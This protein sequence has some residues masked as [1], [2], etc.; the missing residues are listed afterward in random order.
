MCYITANNLVSEQISKQYTTTTGEVLFTPR[1]SPGSRM[2]MHRPS[3]FNMNGK[4]RP[5]PL[6]FSSGVSVSRPSAAAYS[7]ALRATPSDRDFETTD[8]VEFL[9]STPVGHKF[10]RQAAD[11]GDDSETNSDGLLIHGLSRM[12]LRTQ[13]A[14]VFFSSGND[15]EEENLSSSNNNEMQGERYEHLSYRNCALNFFL[16]HLI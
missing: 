13:P 8:D 2:A 7:P 14:S 11:H 9:V 5:S 3:P 15:G 16:I 6:H 4:P 12:S 10:A 1:R